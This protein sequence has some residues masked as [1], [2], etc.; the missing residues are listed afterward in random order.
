NGKVPLQICEQP[1]NEVTYF[2]ALVDASGVSE[3]DIMLLPLFTS[4]VT[5]MGAGNLSY[6]E[7]DQEIQLK[8]G[9]L[10]VSFHLSE[11]PSDTLQ[12]RQV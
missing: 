11:D 12:F 3:E 5:Q 2:R 8:T 7:L 6:K 10:D 9:K 1:T 4:I